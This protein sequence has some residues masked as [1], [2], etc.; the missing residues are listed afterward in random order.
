MC[1]IQCKAKQAVSPLKEIVVAIAGSGGV[2]SI[3]AVV[4]LPHVLILLQVFVCVLDT[5]G[6][7][8]RKIYTM[9][10]LGVMPVTNT[11]T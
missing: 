1:R 3:V 6:S 4:A 5:Q 8:G 11:I 10:A 7:R 9:W 2:V